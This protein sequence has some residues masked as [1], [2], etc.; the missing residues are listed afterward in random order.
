MVKEIKT[1][2]QLDEVIELKFK[3]IYDIKSN[4]KKLIEHIKPF[5]VEKEYLKL[6]KQIETDLSSIGFDVA[7]SDM[8][9]VA[10]SIIKHHDYKDVINKT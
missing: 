7:L 4:T 6:I 9:M 8:L 10:N 1:S 3:K 5:I 2:E